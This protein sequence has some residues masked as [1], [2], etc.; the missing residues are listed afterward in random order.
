[1]K[2]LILITGLLLAATGI[3]LYVVTLP[4]PAPSKPPA[5]ISAAVLD[6]LPQDRKG[7]VLI[8]GAYGFTGAGISKL[9]SEYGITPVLAGRNESKLKPLAES[10]GYDY[11]VLSLEN[12]HDNLVKVLKH[13]EIVLHIAGPYTFTGEP[14]LDAV[15]EAGT[16]YVDLTGENHVIQQQLDRHEE[17]KAANIMVMPSV[18]YDVVPTD[19]LNVYVA[20]QVDNPTNL[21]VVINGNY[22]AAEGAS[23][24]RG[25]MKSGL[26]VMGR[27]LLMRQKGEMVEVS[28]LK[29]IHRVEDGQ[30]QTLVQIPWADMMTSYVSTGV[31]TIEVFQLRQGELPGWLPRVAQ[32]DFGRRIL[33]WLI[34]KFAPE[35]PP[36][37]A[38]ETRQTRIVSTATNDAG[39]SASAAMITPES[40]LFTFHSTL[41]VAKRVIDGHWESGFQTV[42]KVY[43]PDLALEVPGV[44]RMDL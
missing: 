18:G 10:L 44:S 20:D 38:Q 6:R 37:G 43:G 22:T 28:A 23:V 3:G 33:G 15:V 40:Y 39:E 24:S 11:V 36:P 42:G 4:E 13:F 8:Y 17:F 35:G 31:P 21:T 5:P 27:P 2:K 25:T 16:H 26:E 34:D 14:M 29:V 30:E 9:A 7:Q 32:S 12:N 19:C 41:I 1:M